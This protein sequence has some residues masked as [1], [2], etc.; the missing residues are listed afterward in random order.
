MIMLQMPAKHL[1]A[2]V[3]QSYSTSDLFRLLILFWRP[4]LEKESGNNR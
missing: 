3:A 4:C 1:R 2:S